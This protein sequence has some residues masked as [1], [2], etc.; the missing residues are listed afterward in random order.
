MKN[1]LS[2]VTSFYFDD[3]DAEIFDE[4]LQWT[5]FEKAR[6][7]KAALRRQAHEMLSTLKEH[8]AESAFPNIF[9]ALRVYLTIPISNCTGEQLFSHLKRIK[10]AL[11][12]TMGQ[13]RLS[14]LTIP[15]IIYRLTSLWV[16]RWYL[17]LR[18]RVLY[19]C[20]EDIPEGGTNRYFEL[21]LPAK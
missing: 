12:S 16:R 15:D 8:H 17:T 3:L 9:I 2:R 11:C 4:W 6:Y 19:H 21:V 7:P 10:N 18:H 1:T 13:E 20:W 5:E 14:S